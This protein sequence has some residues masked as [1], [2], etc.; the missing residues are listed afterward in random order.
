MSTSELG[1]ENSVNCRGKQVPCDRMHLWM[2]LITENDQQAVA[3]VLLEIIAETLGNDALD[4][5]N[6]AL[7]E[8]AKHAASERQAS[9]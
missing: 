5:V 7:A 4:R 1:D 9:E 8:R 3:S 6:A 2:H